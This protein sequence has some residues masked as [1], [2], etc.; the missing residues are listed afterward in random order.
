MDGVTN[1]ADVVTFIDP[2]TGVITVRTTPVTVPMSTIVRVESIIDPSKYDSCLLTV[3]PPYNAIR[4]WT[5]PTTDPGIAGDLDQGQGGTLLFGTGNSL[6]YNSG[7]D[8]HGVYVIDP[9]N[10]Y[11]FGIETPDGRPRTA[12]QWQGGNANTLNYNLFLFTSTPTYPNHIR[13]SGNAS[14]I[15]RIA[16]LQAPFTIIV[17]YQSNA[18]DQRNADIRIGDKEGLRIQ[19]ELSVQDNDIGPRTVWYSYDPSDPEK[20]EH[21]W[22]NFVPLAFVEAKEGLRLYAVY[23]R[24]GVYVVSPTTG[25]LVPK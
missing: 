1:P 2:E 7:P 10:P 11:Q 9:E 15:M 14:R 6:D 16:A 20:P 24:P 12:G 5:W 4:S 25:K 23:I 22:D 21:G 8:G 13:T 18:T 19:G 3:Y 17:N